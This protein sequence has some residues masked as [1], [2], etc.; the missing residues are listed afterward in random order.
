MSRLIGA[1]LDAALTERRWFALTSIR[2]RR[3]LLCLELAVHAIGLTVAASAALTLHRGGALPVVVSLTLLVAILECAVA[4]PIGKFLT[5]E[6]ARDRACEA[7]L[8]L[9][10]D[11]AH[12]N[13]ACPVSAVAH[14]IEMEDRATAL[15]LYA[16]LTGATFD[17][18]QR[19]VNRLAAERATAEADSFSWQADR[20]LF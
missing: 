10:K 19:A 16:R 6:R 8:A 20:P 7:Y 5:V 4:L 11:E 9:A 17:D 15:I 12:R 14:A 2:A 3:V 13:E 1:V 18:A